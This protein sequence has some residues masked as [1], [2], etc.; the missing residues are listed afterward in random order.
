MTWR[1]VSAC[2]YQGV[3]DGNLFLA[4]DHFGIES[5][6]AE[7]GRYRFTLSNPRKSRL[8]TKR[9][10]LKFD[11]LLPTFACNLNLRRYVEDGPLVPDKSSKPYTSNCSGACQP[12]DCVAQWGQR[13]IGG[14]T[15]G[16]VASGGVTG[17]GAA[18]V[19]AA[20]GGA[21]SGGVTCGGAVWGR[22]RLH[23]VANTYGRLRGLY[24][25]AWR[26]AAGEMRRRGRGD[27]KKRKSERNF[28]KHRL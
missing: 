13:L 5:R 26:A 17:G 27:G 22:D 21:A 15:G 20:G 24:E 7:V 2:P 9:L 14:V 6:L 19:G 8:E 3:F 1:A 18:S 11:Q 28:H 4:H 25:G 12:V 10:E 23:C 16:G